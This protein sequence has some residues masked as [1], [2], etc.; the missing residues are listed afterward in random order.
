MQLF[1]LSFILFWTF[2]IFLPSINGQDY[3]IKGIVEDTLNNPQAYATVVLLEKSDS[4]LV[5]FTRTELDGSFRFKDVTSGNHLIKCTYV[6]FI[7][8]TVDA[9][10]SGQDVDCG[11]LKMSPLNEQLMEVVVKAAKA[12]IKMRGD[13]IEYDASTFQ[14]P[15][16]SS[17]EDLL[18]RLPGMEVEADGS[19]SQ[20]GKNI[21]K[22]TVDGKNFF[23]SDPK[24]AT[25][26][27][28]AEGISKVQV[29]DTKSEQEELT[30][31]TSE[32]QDKTMNLELKEEFKSGG[33]GKIIAGSGSEN[34]GEL[35]G[36]YNKFN[37]KIQFSLVGVA[38]NTGRN[39][40]SWDDYQDFLGSQS[41][42]FGGGTDYGFG[43]GGRF[44]VFGGNSGIEADIQSIFFSGGNSGGFPENYNGGINFN[45]DHKKTKVSSVYYYNQVGIERS[46]ITNQD[47]FLTDFTQNENRDALSNNLS[48]GH[49]AEVKLEQEVDS[50]TTVKVEF[51]GAYIDEEN[52]SS[53]SSS[54][55]RNNILTTANTYS[56][57]EKN[58]GYLLNGLILLRR[59]FMKKGRS[60]GLNASIL[61][62]QL[63]K[64]YD[65]NSNLEFYDD[66]GNLEDNQLILQEN[67]NDQD[68]SVFKANALYVEPLG[69]NFFSQTFYNHRNRSENGDRQVFDIVGN[70]LIT[71]DFLTRTYD[72][73]IIYNRV[74]SSLRYS[75]D[76]TNVTLGL[77][78]QN[79]DLK[80]QATIASVQMIEPVDISFSNWLPYLNINFSPV[81][82]SYID[83]SYSRDANEPDIADLQPF[84]DNINPLY[85]RIGNAA[86]KPEIQNRVSARVSRSYPL[87]GVR[88]SLNGNYSFYQNKFSRNET[89]D[90]DLVT[91]VVPINIDGGS[92]FNSYFSLSFPIVKNKIS[93]RSN[94]NL[95]QNINP[96]IV[97]DFENNTTTFTYAPFVRL[98]I[99]PKKEMSI[100]LTARYR[101][102]NTE[103][104]IAESQNQQ[105]TTTNYG[106][107]IKSKLLFGMFTDINFIYEN[108]QNDRFNQSQS[109][110]ILNASLY[111]PIFSNKAEVR[112]S[113]YDA[114]NQNLGFNQSAS[115]IGIYQSST[116]SLARYIMASVTYNMRGVKTDT[117]KNH[118]W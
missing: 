27:L 116:V 18:R 49:R 91:T 40:L 19:L 101:R 97:N 1:R 87:S 109:I 48:R 25:K 47:R 26:N 55:L 66:Q 4:T 50:L 58:D 95:T 53:G 94:I 14:V 36:N 106:A 64:N 35:K 10:S 78:L 7:P 99:T 92:S 22:V 79:F 80:G 20:D 44:F 65:L 115:G 32:S 57:L 15:E 90:E 96:T 82:N 103:Y 11:I 23:G 21:S 8:L 69:G 13:T 84:V 113:I 59:K 54:L 85:I 2:I 60:L 3:S 76:G 67:L 39:G 111:R 117:R 9:S 71:N 29:F 30:G 46:T 83:I 72:N 114:F 74:G 81:R 112:L 5:E 68:K 108:F 98:S 16:G 37:K 88:I 6:G 12:P 56:N 24:A 31:A 118:W 38:N 73:D 62:T 77:A 86:L 100:Y 43:G 61:N 107:E 33:F 42:N 17:V 28:P 63:D 102:S 45:Y 34:T 75:N 89:V 104:D 93:V 110:P 41:F 105:V 70:E 51:N 52:R